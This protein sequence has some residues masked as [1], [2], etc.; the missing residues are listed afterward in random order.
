MRNTQMQAAIITISAQMR[1]IAR[2]AIA[3]RSA[4]VEHAHSD[5]RWHGSKSC[6]SN[7][8]SCLLGGYPVV[9][10]GVLSPDVFGAKVFDFSGNRSTSAWNGLNSSL[11]ASC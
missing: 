8:R 3:R 1:G 4:L 9:G 2:T 6:K 5:K 7:K 10:V 11:I